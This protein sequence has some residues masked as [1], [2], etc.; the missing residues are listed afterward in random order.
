MKPI[1]AFGE[2]MGRVAMPGFRRFSQCMPGNVEFEFAGAEA[3]VVRSLADL[4]LPTVFVTALPQNELGDACIASLRSNGI[5]TRQI[6]RPDH[7]G[8]Q[9]T[10]VV[11]FGP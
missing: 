1:V 2:I 8:M 5:D 10:V 3:N 11:A 4:G 7:G 9:G 6:L